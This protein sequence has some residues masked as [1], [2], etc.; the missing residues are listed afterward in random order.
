MAGFPKQADAAVPDI[1]I[2]LDFQ[3]GSAE[4]GMIRSREASAP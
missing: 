4:V 3:A 1:L 2:G